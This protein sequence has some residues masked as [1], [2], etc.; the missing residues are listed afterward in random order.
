MKK[1]LV[2]LVLLGCG[3]NA[4]QL[5]PDAA[6]PDAPTVAVLPDLRFKWVGAF[7]RYDADQLSGLAPGQTQT[8]DGQAAWTPFQVGGGDDW[9]KF[10]FTPHVPTEPFTSIAKA[11]EI[12]RAD[13][14]LA[15]V[16]TKGVVVALDFTPTSY[17]VAVT[18]GAG[19]E[20]VHE[21]LA[22][23]AV[24]ATITARAAA[25]FVTTAIAFRGTTVQLYAYRSQTVSYETSV[26]TASIATFEAEATALGAAGFVI[27]AVGRRSETELYLVGTR[28][29][30]A[31]APHE[32]I[33]VELDV[34]GVPQKL[35]EGFSVVGI[36]FVPDG[37]GVILQR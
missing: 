6:G 28:V 36:V 13:A 7:A 31:P 17:A 26:R 5:E 9:Q 1:S 33:V 4:V 8:L 15:A 3:D 14:D 12:D 21:S 24:E 22:P 37:R 18:G 35:A 23:G 32:T 19:S 29:P 30:G 16:E 34:E 11:D 27:T 2:L 20:L 25:G 10:R